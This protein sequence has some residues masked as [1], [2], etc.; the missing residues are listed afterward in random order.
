MFEN[1]QVRATGTPVHA[2]SML[3][4]APR[5]TP[6]VCSSTSSASA[7]YTAPCRT[8]DKLT[9]VHLIETALGPSGASVAAPDGALA[10]GTLAAL[11]FGTLA[12]LAFGTLAALFA[13]VDHALFDPVPP[14][15]GPAP[16]GL[17]RL[18]ECAPTADAARPGASHAVVLA[19]LTAHRLHPA[20]AGATR[21]RA[22]SSPSGARTAAR[23]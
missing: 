4:Q 8:F 13:P 9:H 2:E 11:A 10:F 18:H 19:Q 1:T 3:P 5:P 15:P 16:P 21:V 14:A 23:W 22:C 12:A 7:G 20:L 6:P 17:R